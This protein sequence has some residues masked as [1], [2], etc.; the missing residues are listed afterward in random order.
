VKY[1]ST[2]TFPADTAASQVWFYDD[3]PLY[4][5]YFEFKEGL[6][7]EYRLANGINPIF[8]AWLK[9]RYVDSLAALNKAWGTDYKD[10]FFA[11]VTFPFERP[12]QQSRRRITMI[13]LSSDIRSS[14]SL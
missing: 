9:Y 12:S 4:H 1:L 7:P 11:D 13:S 8:S 5:D 14:G 3:S 10:N 6:K 2:V